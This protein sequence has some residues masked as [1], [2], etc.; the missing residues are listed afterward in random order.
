MKTQ[1]GFTLIELV[2]VIVILGVLSAVALPKF[3][4]LSRDARVATL[5]AAR[6]SISTAMVLVMARSTLDGTSR[7]ADST[8]T[9]GGSVIA[10]KYGYPAYGQGLLD[11]AGLTDP[12][13][14]NSTMSGKG[15]VTYYFNDTSSTN[16]AIPYTNATATSAAVLDP[17]KTNAC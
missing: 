1:T 7:L 3:I 12:F 16:C 11:A 9:I 15:Y 10:I 14:A 4:D 5:N 2:M 6:G 13:F 8:V 17:T